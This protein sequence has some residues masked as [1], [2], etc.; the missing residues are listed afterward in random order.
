M[1][2]RRDGERAGNSAVVNIDHCA[3]FG[4]A[5]AEPAVF[6]EALAQA[7]ESLGDGLAAETGERLRAQ[8]HLDP[9][10]DPLLRQV[11]RKRRAVPGLL[12]DGLVVQDDAADRLGGAGSREQHL[13]IAAA[14]LLGRLQ[15]D[16]IEALLDGAAALVRG[17]DALAPGDHCAGNAHQLTR[18]HRRILRRRRRAHDDYPPEIGG[19]K[20]SKS[21]RRPIARPLRPLR[22]SATLPRA[23]GAATGPAWFR[24]PLVLN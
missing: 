9:R 13:A 3:P 11:L 19:A 16:P 10:D 2:V 17:Q 7:V 4:E 5:R 12:A 15:L 21:A 20:D 6:D 1:R 24:R 18:V 8:A 22:P 14:M 23:L